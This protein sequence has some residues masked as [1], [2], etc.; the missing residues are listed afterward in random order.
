MGKHLI[1]KPGRYS[2]FYCYAGRMEAVSVQWRTVRS[3]PDWVVR[4]EL[5]GGVP[6]DL[7]GSNDPEEAKEMAETLVDRWLE[8]IGAQWKTEEGAER[9]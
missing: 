7:K 5:S 2:A 8:S 1:W 3:G 9:R 6:E 4:T